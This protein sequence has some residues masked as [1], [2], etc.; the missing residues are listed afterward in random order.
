M[1]KAHFRGRCL[2]FHL[3]FLS[4][5]SFDLFLQVVVSDLLAALLWSF[6]P[7]ISSYVFSSLALYLV[8]AISLSVLLVKFPIRVLYF[9][10]GSLREHRFYHRLISI[11][12]KL[13]RFGRRR[14][15][16][17]HSATGQYTQPSRNTTA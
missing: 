2:Y 4:P 9:C 7:Y 13:A 14:L 11:R 6:H 1:A 16:R 3:C 17:R 5:I 10:S 15:R 8:V 12:H